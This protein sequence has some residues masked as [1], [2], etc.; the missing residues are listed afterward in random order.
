MQYSGGCGMCIIYGAT[1][2]CLPFA[3]LPNMPSYPVMCTCTQQ[4]NT[5]QH[6]TQTRTVA[7]TRKRGD[8][9]RGFFP[10]G[11]HETTIH[12]DDVISVSS[13]KSI[14]RRSAG[15][16]LFFPI[17]TGKVGT[18]GYIWGTLVYWCARIL[19][20]VLCRRSN[21]SARQTCRTN[22]RNF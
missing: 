5:A 8:D 15:P 12:D 21:D 1:V 10:G 11:T 16:V 14:R 3:C 2:F 18:M 9:I 13:R 4:H 22:P 20:I 6:S 19:R 17:K 7:Y